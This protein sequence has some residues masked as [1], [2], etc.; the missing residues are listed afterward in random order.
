MDTAVG[1][2]RNYQDPDSFGAAPTPDDVLAVIL[3]DPLERAAVVAE[4]MGYA[5]PEDV[6]GMLTSPAGQAELAYTWSRQRKS[7][8]QLW[9]RRAHA[10]AAAASS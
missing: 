5:T 1:R 8:R 9:R 6:V 3:A 10:I 2:D 4:R 7:T